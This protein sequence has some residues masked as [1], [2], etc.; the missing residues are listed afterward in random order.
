MQQEEVLAQLLLHLKVLESM[1]A[2][3]Q[4]ETCLATRRVLAQTIRNMTQ[5]VQTLANQIKER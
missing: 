4:K 2:A 1:V 3:L 5:D